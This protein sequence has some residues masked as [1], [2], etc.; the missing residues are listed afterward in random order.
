M[1]DKRLWIIDG[2]AELPGGDLNV[3]VLMHVNVKVPE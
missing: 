2:S 3:S 1:R